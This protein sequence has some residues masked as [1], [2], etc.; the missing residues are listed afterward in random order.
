MS[1]SSLVRK[2]ACSLATVVPGVVLAQSGFGPL[3]GEYAIVGALP[4]DQVSPALS[5]KADGG[6]IVW[7]DNATDGDGW[8]ISAR[9]LD[10]SLQGALAPFRVNGTSKA[11]QEN[12]RVAVLNGGG[13]VFVWQG[14]R[15]GFQHIY[16]RFLST[17]NTWLGLDQMVNASGKTYQANPAVAV[18]GNG[19]VV[20][21][22]A[23]FNAGTMQD[24]YGQIFSPDGVK[25]GGE[26]PINTFTAY[27][28]R[29]P[30]VAALTNGGFVV[31]WVSE[32]QR[33]LGAVGADPVSP[34]QFQLPSVD[35]YARLFDA[36]GTPVISEFPVNENSDVNANP[37]VAGAAD[38][39]VL[40]AWSSK[41]SKILNNGW[42]VYVRTFAFPGGVPIGPAER[43]ANGPQLFGDQFA[44]RVASLGTN[45]MVVWT[46]LGQDGSGAGIFG[47]FLNAD[48]S[49]SGDD[50]RMNTS[51]LGAQQ[52]PAVV[53]DGA[54]R[55][56]TAWTGPSYTPSRNDLFARVYAAG[57][58][59]PPASS[60][61]YNAP[62][63]VGDAPAKM[64]SFSSKFVP[65]PY[66]EPPTLGYPG[67]ISI[68]GSGEPA[69][70]AF[71]LAAG[72]YTG[73]FYEVNGVSPASSGYFTARTY[74][75]KGYSAKLTIGGKTYSV[76]NSF[77]EFGNSKVATIKR[78]S[79]TPLTVTF[80]EDL[81]GL[82]RIHG[83]VRAGS[84]WTA[85]LVADRQVFNKTDHPAALAGS[86]T[87]AI[88]GVSTGLKGPAGNGFG[89]MTLD[90]AG[91]LTWVV[92]LADKTR[93][94]NAPKIPGTIS[95][96]GVWPLY[97]SFSGGLVIGWIQFS[98]SVLVPNGAVTGDLI[99]FKTASRTAASYKTGYTNG[100]VV[101]GAR[102]VPPV[103]GSSLVQ[104][105]GAG[106]GSNQET[107][108]E[109][110]AD[111]TTHKGVN[112]K[113]F[114]LNPRKDGSFSGSLLS[115]AVSFQGVLLE[116]G[117]GAGFFI[118]K[119]QSG[120]LT[121]KQP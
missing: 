100:A 42:D 15:Q 38:G 66:I 82:D 55:F 112:L 72:D 78:G 81:F 57:N 47:R 90:T 46:S 33:S 61:A 45:Y 13:A 7:Q 64:D 12:A 94:V 36:A 31:G 110:L 91:K 3:G 18:L 44:P 106:L 68:S 114:T 56:L 1:F 51:I 34:A 85:T 63:Y 118:N 28:Q 80:Q 8:G 21:V 99:S 111:N 96:S 83:E 67:M 115:P 77:D 92:T 5:V 84:D 79:L 17:S 86:Y 50:L 62:G 32:Q 43:R 103:S 54:G 119:Q 70:N 23:S 75:G 26:F 74:A 88:P 35:I 48:G 107:T 71:A 40:F 53:A 10:S 20:I 108:V 2:L 30:T 120:P 76:T 41:D 9:V 104:L 98:N 24:V 101:Y 105:S 95:K 102:Y 87:M 69:T 116:N 27:N 11:D 59:V 16:A 97:G 29:T 22:Y 65:G 39:S 89:T 121:L 93:I 113:S 4:G 14:G 19:N 60:I 58:F 6:Y 49:S 73:L 52:E 109:F 117:A 25:V 37:V